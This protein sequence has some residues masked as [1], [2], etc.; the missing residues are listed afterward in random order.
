MVGEIRRLS[1]QRTCQVDADTPVAM[2]VANAVRTLRDRGVLDGDTA[3]EPPVL[4]TTGGSGA[5]VAVLAEPG[6]D[7]LARELS[8]A[9]TYLA[10]SLSGSTVLLAPHELSA[11]TAGSWGA[12]RLVHIDGS[13]VE[14]D[15]ASAVAGW[16]APSGPGQ[17]SLARPPPGARSLSGSPPRSMP[18]S[19]AM[20]LT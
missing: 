6:H 15:I 16:R 2:Q 17:S 20:P 12:D 18:G 14:E 11:A 9:A 5:V 8:G 19:P 10:A 4:A 13:A 7:G 3:P 1:V